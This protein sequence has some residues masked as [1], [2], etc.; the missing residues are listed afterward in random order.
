[1]VNFVHP[2]TDRW[3]KKIKLSNEGS[4]ISPLVPILLASLNCQTLLN[5]KD[6]NGRGVPDRKPAGLE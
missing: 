3:K 2:D 4:C 1:V 6:L 5:A